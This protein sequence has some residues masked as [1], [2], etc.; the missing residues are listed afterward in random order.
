MSLPNAIAAAVVCVLCAGASPVPSRPD[1]RLEC[2]PVALG[3][4]TAFVHD[5]DLLL[6]ATKWEEHD[7]DRIVPETSF[8]GMAVQVEAKP[9]VVPGVSWIRVAE[10][11]VGLFLAQFGGASVRAL[12]VEGRDS[13]LVAEERTVSSSAERALVWG[14]VPLAGFREQRAGS[15]PQQSE[16]AGARRPARDQTEWRSLQAVRE[17]SVPG[18]AVMVDIAE[19]SLVSFK[20]RVL[21]AGR[22][23]GKGYVTW[24]G[25]LADPHH[26]VL[27]AVVLGPGWRP[28]LVPAGES[29]FCFAIHKPGWRPVGDFRGSLVA[30][31][32]PD[33]EQWQPWEPRVPLDDVVRVDGCTE[34]D[35][36]L[37]A[38]LTAPPELRIH[39][40]R[41]DPD[42]EGLTELLTVDPAR[43]GELGR[44]IAI[45]L[46]KGKPYLFWQDHVGVAR[47]SLLFGNA[48]GEGKTYIVMRPL[49]LPAP[50]EAAAED[51]TAGAVREGVRGTEGGVVQQG[52]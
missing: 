52:G 41:L 48:A 49:D 35:M 1:L 5:E 43:E 16:N 3:G 13:A 38:C 44:D 47:E 19:P 14:K 37:V 40:Y 23:T 30:W 27:D 36:T 24:V 4:W 8:L 51:A 17:R 20:N 9:G 28:A 22:A 42:E 7:A 11:A 32:S 25:E 31:K 50:D 34:G 6:V 26:G 10:P 46:L 18:A 33:A 45:R 21:V 2:L 15:A 39:V 29:L 12:A